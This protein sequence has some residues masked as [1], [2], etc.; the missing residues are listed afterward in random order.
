[1]KFALFRPI[2]LYQIGILA[3]I[4]RRGRFFTFSR[5]LLG[6]LYGFQYLLEG[7]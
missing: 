5:L 7:R 4:V 1:M 3:S 6:A 2:F